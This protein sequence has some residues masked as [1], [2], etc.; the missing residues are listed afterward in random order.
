[1][2]KLPILLSIYLLS[3]FGSNKTVTIWLD[4]LSIKSFSEGIP[5][6]LPKTTAAGDSMRI[7]NVVYARGVGVQAISV[8]AFYL[9]GHARQFSA[10]V[11]VDDR[12]NKNISAAFYVI[13]D[14]KIVFASGP[15]QVGDQ[16]K[17]VH[18]TL[19]SIK[20]LG[21]LVTS[22]VDT[23]PTPY[24]NWANARLE[25][26]AKHEPDHIPNSE[27][28]YILTPKPASSPRINSARIFGA[29]PGHPFFYAIAASGKRPMKFSAEHLPKGLFLDPQSGLISGKMVQAGTYQVTLKAKNE[30]GTDTKE[31]QIRIGDAI[32]LTPPMGWNGW[33]SWARNI[34]REKVIASANAMVSK[35]L[36]DHGWSFINIDDAWQGRRGGRYN[37]I[38]PNE[39]FPDFKGMIDYIHTQGLKV[40]LYSTPWI[41]SY[42]GYTGGSS[43]IE[44]GVFPDSVRQN[45]R[46]YRYIGKYR[47]ENNDA[48]QWA[49][50]GIDYLKYDWRIEAPSAERM[51]VA[52]KGSGR[53]I[54]YSLANSAPFTEATAWSRLA[55]TW[56]TGPDIRDSW[57]SLF[58]SAFTI[59]TWAP[60][61]GPGHWNDP[62]MLILGNVTTGSEMHPSRL[63]PD[64]Q[65]SHVSLFSLLA[66][67]LLIGCP[68]EQ[69]D[70]FTLNLLTNDDVIAVNQDPLGKPARLQHAE[71][72]VQVWLKPMADGSYAVGLFNVA[73]FSETPQSYFR[74]GDET[75]TRFTFKFAQ[76]GLAGKWRLRDIWRQ[77]DLGTFSGC[78]NSEIPHHGVIMLRM[79][80]LQIQQK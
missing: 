15:M 20:R 68:I 11:G 66:A 78:F 35:G 50:W 25:M 27:F 48:K 37:G 6:V 17:I 22:D 46:A 76:A 56:R 4:D 45:K 28:R 64:E 29:T 47:F 53:D 1:M 54:V 72:G 24:A 52:L 39:K 19:D 8:M 30:L 69:L 63:T 38:Q 36:R 55:N 31:L 43:E 73:H 12:A 67:P 9:N 7:N 3:L 2:T 14:R 21:L 33:N 65:Y 71:H 51:A 5:A 61:A 32:A 13:A 44:S 26:D 49:E 80:K 40:G 60:F 77:K 58:F 16:P 41:A 42:A 59:D 75:P 23:H 10:V 74:W 34:D 18:V 62:D 57:T 79:K 70:D